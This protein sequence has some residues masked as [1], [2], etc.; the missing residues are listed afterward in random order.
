[1]VWHCQR[2]W[3]THVWLTNSPNTW[4]YLWFMCSG[5]LWPCSHRRVR[6]CDTFLWTRSHQEEGRLWV[7]CLVLRISGVYWIPAVERNWS[8]CSLKEGT[9]GSLTTGS[10]CFMEIPFKAHL[11]HYCFVAPGSLFYAN[12]QSILFSFQVVPCFD[13]YTAVAA[14]RNM[15]LIQQISRF[16]CALLS[17]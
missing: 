17:F 5:H 10:S 15:D 9:Y 14:K 16:S 3:F 4:L 2:S 13:M 7:L 12:T 8:I 11:Y 6:V 1:M